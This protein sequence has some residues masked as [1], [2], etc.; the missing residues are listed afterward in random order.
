M[1][2]DE[3]H[4][5]PSN[6]LGDEIAEMALLMS[7]SYKEMCELVGEKRYR[8]HLNGSEPLHLLFQLADRLEECALAVQCCILK[9]DHA[10][11]LH[12]YA[13]DLIPEYAGELKRQYLRALFGVPSDL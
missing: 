13:H 11:L 4:S 9:R 12:I 6:Q 7:R 1:E 5:V 10:R 3:T 8:E 2:H